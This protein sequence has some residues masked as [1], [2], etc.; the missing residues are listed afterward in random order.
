LEFMAIDRAREMIAQAGPVTDL[1][2]VPLGPE[3]GQCCGGRV[4]IDIALVDR[5]LREAI[6][7]RIGAED[8]MRP[9]VYLFGGGHVG[10]AL[11]SALVLLPLNVTVVE[12]RADALDEMP[13]GV[14]TRLT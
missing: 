4:K 11:A 5:E 13:D 8:A 6:P 1:L 14:A 2:D 3:I 10:H 12:T 7:T 9:H